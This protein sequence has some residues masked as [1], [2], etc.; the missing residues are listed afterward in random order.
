MRSQAAAQDLARMEGRPT[1]L[2]TGLPSVDRAL[3]GGFAVGTATLVAARP[4]VGATSFLIGASLN[5]LMAGNKVAY[6]TQRLNPEQLRGRF[7]VLESRVN[8]YRFR[9]GFVSAQD[10]IAL[11]AARDRIPWAS[12]TTLAKRQLAHDDLDAH[13]FS[14]RPWLV[15]ADLVPSYRSWG[16]SQKR[17]TILLGFERLAAMARRHR[18]ALVLRW[19]LNRGKHAPDP[20]ELPGLGDATS[21]FDSVML[22]HR[23]LDQDEDNPEER[24]MTDAEANIIRVGGKDIRPRSVPLRFDQR[25]AGLLE[26]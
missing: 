17:D 9:A 6:F 14:Y 5:N 4:K 21:C 3:G 16:T 19:I 15:V 10:R 24:P 11:L 25:F 7:V 1:H 2:C 20:L 26:P 23:Q 18:V 12:L 22:L 13:I 8:G